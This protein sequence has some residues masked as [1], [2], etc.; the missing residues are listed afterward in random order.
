MLPLSK[1]GQFGAAV[2][3]ATTLS[4]C[5]APAPPPDRE[6]ADNFALAALDGATVQLAD[7]LGDVV[8]LNFWAS[9]SNQSQTQLPILQGWLFIVLGLGLIEHPAKHRLHRYL[10]HRFKLYRRVAADLYQP[11]DLR[12]VVIGQ[13]EGVEPVN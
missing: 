3:L 1:L 12:F 7:Y 13:P 8:F 6:D 2:A 4:G 5:P 9:W 11:E 10:S